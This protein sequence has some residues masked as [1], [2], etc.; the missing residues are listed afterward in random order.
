MEVSEHRQQPSTLTERE[1]AF[2]DSLPAEERP[3]ALAGLRALA[4]RR[5]NDAAERRALGLDPARLPLTRPAAQSEPELEPVSVTPAPAE[6]PAPA[7]PAFITYL[8]LSAALV[9]RHLADVALAYDL[10][11]AYTRQQRGAGEVLRRGQVIEVLRAAGMSQ[12]SAERALARG[13]GL[14]WNARTDR[15][16][17]RVRWYT[18]WN[19]RRAVAALALP[20]GAL[21]D[22]A[23]LPAVAYRHTAATY[24]AHVVGAWLQAHPR[25]SRAEQAEAF[26]R[27]ERQIREMQRA[28]GQ[29]Q[30]TVICHAGAPRSDTEGLE[31]AERLTTKQGEPNPAWRVR[32]R[33]YWQST[34][35]YPAGPARLLRRRSAKSERPVSPVCTSPDM[36]RGATTDWGRRPR[37][38]QELQHAVGWQQRHAGRGA[39]VYQ[40]DLAR[41]GPARSAQ[42]EKGTTLLLAYRYSRAA[43]WGIPCI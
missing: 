2:L 16:D 26:G 14:C 7:A 36:A 3:A 30:Q 11:K 9:K 40:A 23:R 18:L 38:F 31:L 43:L 33:V 28:A 17:R 21:C 6:T 20:G 15:R 12:R 42:R 24:A 25:S 4:Q 10:W 37:H 22:R 34:N 27:T 41:S 39:Y 5:A 1:R 8:G 29:P 35:H 13:G 19:P 32:D